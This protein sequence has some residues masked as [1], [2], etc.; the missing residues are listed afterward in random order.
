MLRAS[1]LGAASR[2]PQAA[3]SR[4][5]CQQERPRSPHTCSLICLDGAAAGAVGYARVDGG[6]RRPAAAEAKQRVTCG[7]LGRRGGGWGGLCDGSRGVR[8]WR[9]LQ[10]EEVDDDVHTRRVTHVTYV[11][12][13]P[14]DIQAT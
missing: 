8:V 13:E 5:P 12:Y 4:K 10:D 6:A 9:R 11:T 1:R 3:R 14:R 7:V 2:E